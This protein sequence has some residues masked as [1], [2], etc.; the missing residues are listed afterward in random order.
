[1][2]EPPLEHGFVGTDDRMDGG[3]RPFGLQEIPLAC[4]LVRIDRRTAGGH[5]T[6]GAQATP[7]KHGLCGIAVRFSAS[8]ALSCAEVQR[9][10]PDLSKL[11]GG[12]WR[13]V[14]FAGDEFN[15]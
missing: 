11:S 1:M 10:H 7:F 2:Q 13:R 6:I 12:S 14:A 9:A 15:T 3:H 4:G 8:E 5:G